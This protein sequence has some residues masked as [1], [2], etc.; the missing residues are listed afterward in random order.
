[1]LWKGKTMKKFGLVIF[2]AGI[3]SVILGIISVLAGSAKASPCP[4]WLTSQVTGQCLTGIQYETIEYLGYDRVDTNFQEGRWLI[5][6][7]VIVPD[8]PILLG[9]NFNTYKLKVV[10][11]F[12]QHSMPSLYIF[13]KLVCDKNGSLTP[14]LTIS[15]PSQTGYVANIYF[16][17]INMKEMIKT[18][19]SY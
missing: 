7:Q 12:R 3:I 19:C 13:S 8:K 14:I 10:G 16:A 18:P 15:I 1:M 9:S 11:V 5:Q 17:V 6:K 2:I 4:L